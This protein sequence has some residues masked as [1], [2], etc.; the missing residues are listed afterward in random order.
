METIKRE[1]FSQPEAL[2]R[3]GAALLIRRKEICE[4]LQRDDSSILFIGCGSGYMLSC[5]GAYL[6]NVHTNRKAV[7]LTGGEVMLAPQRYKNLFRDAVVV[8]TSR[9]GETSEVVNA[10][11][12][13]KELVPFRMLGILA[14]ENCSMEKMVD[15]CVSIP[16]A[17]DESICQTRTI[18]NFFYA[19][20]MLYAMYAGDESLIAE[21]S[22]C[23]DR[24]R[25]YLAQ[26]DGLCTEL[27]ERDWNNVTVLSDGDVC[28]VAQESALAFTEISTV[29]SE[30]SGFLDYRH[31]LVAVADMKKLVIALLTPGDVK[32][33]NEMV[34]EIR[35][36]GSI[37]V[38]I[39][40]GEAS[41]WN[42]NY[43]I[44]LKPG[45]RT[46]TW[47]LPLV[48]FCQIMAFRKALANDHDPDVPAGLKAYVK[49]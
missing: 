25:D 19:L 49:L 37:V 22:A 31:G 15:L 45:S 30:H 32:Q 48:N 24:Q 11:R 36:R 10:L 23:I 42:S 40:H 38:T 28:G 27:A 1:I 3:T 12:E 33:Q 6:F 26:I 18:S 4:F 9:S 47:G 46:E 21:F 7:A 34:S 5:G 8:V 20:D 16:W 17:Y 43:H 13:M 41:Q 29:P 39:G 35:D 14:K 44:A 2:R